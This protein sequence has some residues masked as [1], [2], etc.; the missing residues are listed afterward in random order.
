M[1]V[2][3]TRYTL[4]TAGQDVLDSVVIYGDRYLWSMVMGVVRCYC[5]VIA[6]SWT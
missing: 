3:H 5:F 6:R 2:N 1:E 4:D